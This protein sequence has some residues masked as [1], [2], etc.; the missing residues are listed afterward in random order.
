MSYPYGPLPSVW[1]YSLFLNSKL[2]FIRTWAF[3]AALVLAFSMIIEPQASF[4]TQR[5][6]ELVKESFRMQSDVSVYA[7]HYHR[8]LEDITAIIQRSHEQTAHRLR[9]ANQGYVE[10]L[11]SFDEAHMDGR[12]HQA[13][14]EDTPLSTT[15]DLSHLIDNPDMFFFGWDEP[16]MGQLGN[17]FDYEGSSDL[18][19]SIL[20]E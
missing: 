20:R 17:I 19:H 9:K 18:T 13:T 16:S 3:S 4:K 7:T 2:C 10:K 14:V 8:I 12:D 5:A 11:F 15:A 1:L 6:F